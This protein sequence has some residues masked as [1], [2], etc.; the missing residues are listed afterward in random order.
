MRARR[1][2]GEACRSCSGPRAHSSTRPAKSRAMPAGSSRVSWHR[3]P[4]R[5]RRGR[6]AA[7]SGL[8][9]AAQ[10]QAR[11]GRAIATGHSHAETCRA[12]RRYQGRTLTHPDEMLFAEAGITKEGLAEC[13]VAVSGRML[14]HVS[15][16]PLSL[17]RC[18]DGAGKECFFQKHTMKGMPSALK[19]VP[20]EEG[21]GETA[22]YLMIDSA[23]G[24]SAGADRWA[25]NSPVGL[26]LEDVERPDRMVFDLDPDPQVKF[27]DVREAARDVRKL[28]E[29]ANIEK[30][31]H[32]DGRQRH[33][34]RSAAQR[35]AE[36]GR[37]QV[38]RPG[39][40]GEACRERARPLRRH[41]SKAK[42]KG[43]HLHRLAAQRA[44]LDR[45]CALFAARKAD[46]ERRH[47]GVMDRAVPL[48]AGNAFTIPSVLRRLKQAKSDPWKGYFSVRQS[49]GRKAAQFF[50]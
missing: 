15:G 29:A 37:D 38:V 31:R 49:I 30:L 20:V 11:R 27:A 44:R 19:S 28:L 1:D 25:R 34:R 39:R 3:S 40:R 48:E 22:E 46:R 26:A 32:G 36:L 9:G 16:R 18:P 50:A 45:D 6:A 10:R 33:S 43:P 5:R 7:A 35:D 21:D 24:S 47:A 13:L 14:P 8:P 4:I 12:G 23:A 42:R 17:V 2:L 41:L